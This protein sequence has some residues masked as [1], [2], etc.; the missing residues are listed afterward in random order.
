MALS[1]DGAL[2]E[3]VNCVYTEL[4][5]TPCTVGTTVGVPIMDTC[6]ECETGSNGA[7]WGHLIDIQPGDTYTGDARTRRKPC[8]PVFWWATFRVTLFRCF[9]TIDERGEIPSA[10]ELTETAADAHLDA[11]AMTRALHCCSIGGEPVILDAV[12]VTSDPSGGCSM[13]SALFKVPVDIRW[14]PRR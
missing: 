13:L 6:C 8:A 9:P 4:P 1:I 5:V 12:T 10:E 2:N 14:Q 11:A 7:L 3:A